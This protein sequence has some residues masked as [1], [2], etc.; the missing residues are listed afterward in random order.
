MQLRLF[1]DED[2]H[3]RTSAVSLVLMACECYQFA[4]KRLHKNGLAAVLKQ[5]VNKQK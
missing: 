3:V 5:Q 1:L 4:Q 2:V